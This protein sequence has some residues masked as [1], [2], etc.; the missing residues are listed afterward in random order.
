MAE[1][2]EI[3]GKSGKIVF[4]DGSPLMT[5]YLGGGI[6]DGDSYETMENNVLLAISSNYVSS[7]VLQEIAKHL[8]PLNSFE[9]KIEKLFG[10]LPKVVQRYRPFFPTYV[11]TTIQRSYAFKISKPSENK[12]KAECLLCKAADSG[13]G[14]DVLKEDYGLSEYLEKP[15]KI[16][17]LNGTH[18]TLL[19]NPELAVEINKF[20]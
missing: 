11:K 1:T 20:L 8:N 7:E 18:V 16:V 9:E 19:E 10:I 2:L 3:Q 12:I 6:L 14:K 4:I 15:L 17:Q 13:I 5:R